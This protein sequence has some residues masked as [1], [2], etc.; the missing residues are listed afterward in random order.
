MT[1]HCPVV[2]VEGIIGAGKSTLCERACRDLNLFHV[3]EPVEDNPYLDAFYEDQKRW[4]LHMQ[5]W[6]VSRRVKSVLQAKDRIDGSEYRGLMVDRSILGDRVFAEIHLANGNISK[7]MWPIYD[8]F[9]TNMAMVTPPPDV[10]VYLDVTPE[11]ALTHVKQ[12]GRGSEQAGVTLAYERKLKTAYD[13]MVDR[14]K[15]ELGD[16]LSWTMKTSV[17]T[18]D[19]YL[20][21]DAVPRIIEQIAMHLDVANTSVH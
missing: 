16:Q 14:V 15:N 2:A 12:R 9:F 6:L 10:L 8:D 4:A 1:R 20:R 21:D 19:G 3:P 7:E 11:E 13:K 5:M 17:I 18:V